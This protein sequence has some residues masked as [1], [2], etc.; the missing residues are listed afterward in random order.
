MS[1][2]STNTFKPFFEAFGIY[3]ALRITPGPVEL[4][5]GTGPL[6]PRKG[7]FCLH[8]VNAAYGLKSDL[9]ALKDDLR[10]ST[11]PAGS[12]DN[13]TQRVDNPLRAI[14]DMACVDR[15]VGPAARIESLQ[16]RAAEAA[17]DYG[18]WRFSN[19]IFICWNESRDATFAADHQRNAANPVALSLLAWFGFKETAAFGDAVVINPRRV[20]AE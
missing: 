8:A 9:L 16:L 10:I 13:A 14:V 12:V 20:I 11:E 5:D 6:R 19:V 2:P 18:F 4:G 15:L 3:N 1:R 7:L 17:A